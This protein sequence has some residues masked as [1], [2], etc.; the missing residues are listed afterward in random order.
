M[1]RLLHQDPSDL[2]FYMSVWYQTLSASNARAGVI[3][4]N[5]AVFE[6]ASG[7]KVQA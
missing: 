6:G 2:G 7:S 3:I 1:A 5:L 4:A